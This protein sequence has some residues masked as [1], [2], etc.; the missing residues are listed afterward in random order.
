[1]PEAVESMTPMTSLGHLGQGL[2][3]I[4]NGR[5]GL[6]REGEDPGMRLGTIHLHTRGLAPVPDGSMEDS[7]ELARFSAPRLV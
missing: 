4:G 7:F 3:L 1:M 6:S 2:S 5:G